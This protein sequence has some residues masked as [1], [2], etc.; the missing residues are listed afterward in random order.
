M[1]SSL[2]L[3][4]KGREEVGK[5]KRSLWHRQRELVLALESMK[6]VFHRQCGS[7]LETCC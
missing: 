3:R 6:Q 1:I 2:G 4:S 7:Y 5:G